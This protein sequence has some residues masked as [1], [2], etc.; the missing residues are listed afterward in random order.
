M[1]CRDCNGTGRRREN[2]NHPCSA[3]AGR[4]E[5]CEECNGPADEGYSYYEP[6]PGGG[7][8]AYCRRCWK[9]L[10]ASPF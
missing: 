2:E 4:G 9:G 10:E 6:G 1:I 3:C 7:S 8:R 5:R